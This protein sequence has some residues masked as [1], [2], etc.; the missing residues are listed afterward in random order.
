MLP[1]RLIAL[2]QLA[3]AAERAAAF[4]YQGHAASVSSEKEREH[5]RVIEQEEWDHRATLAEWMERYDVK[6]S[7][8]RELEF[9]VIGR[10]ISLSCHVI[11]WFLPMYF[12]GRLESGNVIEYLV[13]RDLFHEVGITEHDECL[14][15]MADTEKEHELYFLGLIAEHPW[16]PWFERRFGWGPGRSFNE[17][18]IAETA[19]ST[20]A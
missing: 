11:G 3:H 2:M 18:E 7:W 14:V 10:V 8:W 17:H 4:A 9:Y 20:T 1:A 15:E 13:M 16:T 12:A 6:R 19:E 5:I